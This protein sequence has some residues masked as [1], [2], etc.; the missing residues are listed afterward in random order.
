[1]IADDRRARL[2]QWLATELRGAAFT[3]TPAS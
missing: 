1:M 3:L 2:E